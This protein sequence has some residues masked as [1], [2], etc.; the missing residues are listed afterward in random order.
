MKKL[1]FIMLFCFIFSFSVSAAE[2]DIYEEQY[3]ISGAEE[4]NDFLDDETRNF[5]EINGIDPKNPDWVNS[6]KNENIISHIIDFIK[7][8]AKAPARAAAAIIGII[9]ISA[10]VTAFGEQTGRFEPALFAATLAVG[11]VIAADIWGVVSSAAEA[12]LNYGFSN[13][14]IE[15]LVEENA[16]FGMV[17]VEKGKSAQVEAVTQSSLKRLVNK[18]SENKNGHRQNDSVRNQANGRRGSA[19]CARAARSI[20][21]S[22]TDSSHGEHLPLG[23]SYF[24]PGREKCQLPVCT[25]SP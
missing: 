18:Q 9:L 15:T 7:S 21:L 5:L 6:I 3:E 14:K 8:G 22:V 24:T 4:I 12:L 2:T 1:I 23:W 17:D 10:A 19:R 16:S 25:I 11:G 20:L 13:Y